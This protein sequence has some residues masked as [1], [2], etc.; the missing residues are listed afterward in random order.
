[1]VKF[2]PVIEQTKDISEVNTGTAQSPGTAP[3]LPTEDDKNKMPPIIR[4][5]LELSHSLLTAQ[6]LRMK[7]C[8][9]YQGG[10]F[11]Q[12]RPFC[13]ACGYRDGTRGLNMDDKGNHMRLKDACV[14]N[15]LTV[16][17]TAMLACQLHDEGKLSLTTPIIDVLPDL[18]DGLEGPAVDQYKA[19]TPLSI[20][21]FT[22][23][24]DEAAVLKTTG[25][26][27][28]PKV[29]GRGSWNPSVDYHSRFTSKIDRFFG[30]GIPPRLSP[31]DA[32]DAA[33]SVNT[34]MSSSTAGHIPVN[35]GARR[36]RENLV[37]FVN[38][39]R[40][41]VKVIKAQLPK[42]RG[43]L[44]PHFSIALLA[45]AMEKVA[46]P[47]NSTSR[48]S[49]MPPQS[50]ESSSPKFPSAFEDQMYERLFKPL[51]AYSAGYGA[52]LPW[53]DP[54]SMFYT[55]SGQTA[56]HTNFSTPVPLAAPLNAGPLLFNSSMNLY[57]PIEEFAAL[58]LTATD[59]THRNYN[60][61]E[62]RKLIYPNHTELLRGH[63][64]EVRFGLWFDKMTEIYQGVPKVWSGYDY[65]PWAANMRY[66]SK[67]D[68][69]TFGVCNAGMR[70]SR[71]FAT[72]A[73]KAT[74]TIFMNNVIQKKINV[75]EADENS[76]EVKEVNEKVEKLQTKNSPFQRRAD[77]HKRF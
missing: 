75:F 19:L 8:P 26:A 72:T 61:P 6:S 36:Y 9:G 28:G 14:F 4:S 29:L 16:P 49:F 13:F 21:S 56:G 52:P 23:T 30:A 15:A 62:A 70:R 55:P 44:V 50:G 65:L 66:N 22:A 18:V 12:G 40:G 51:Q 35:E 20:L 11:Y 3:D 73:A 10:L 68:I 38:S 31:K 59:M 76:P 63:D 46:P 45:A 5:V 67:H 71:W 42:R 60:D 1:M 57:A 58:M 41:N 27:S 17:I 33:A 77:A 34:G 54:N 37:R 64:G 32:S 47:V 2:G 53:R 43:A 7:M 69:G 48:G 74:E 24:L 25:V 39:T